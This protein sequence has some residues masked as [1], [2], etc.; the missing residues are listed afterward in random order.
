MEEKKLDLNTIIGFVLI[1]VLLIWVLYNNKPTEAEL[2]AQK[3][4]KEKVEAQKTTENQN[5]LQDNNTVHEGQNNVVATDSVALAKY[6][7]Q[8]G[9]FAY[10]ASLPSANDE[11]TILENEDV[12][13]VVSNK[14]GQITE[15]LLKKFDTYDEQPLYLIKDQNAHF[16]LEFTTAQNQTLH[17]KDLFLN[18]H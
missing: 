2:A 13:L 15:V 6:A 1:F 7:S 4:E 12:K 3:A 17:T 5:K 18:H 8:L 16:S 10:S 9:A 11:K 14:G